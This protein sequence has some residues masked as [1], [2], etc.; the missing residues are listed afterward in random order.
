MKIQNNYAIVILG[1]N[2]LVPKVYTEVIYYVLIPMFLVLVLFGAI[3][4][5][6]AYK[7]KKGIDVRRRFK[8]NYW[9]SIAGIIF[10]AVLFSVALGFACA[11]IQKLYV[12]EL[13][14]SY[15]LLVIALCV[16]PIICFVVMLF[17]IIRLIRLL[18]QQ[19]LISQ[20]SEE[21]QL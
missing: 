17:C 8:V 21:E 16:L 9:A 7:E 4:I 5:V 19:D 15:L 3:L 10:G 11:M 13:V 18:K 12:H 6:M 2:M 20:N 14:N 1:D